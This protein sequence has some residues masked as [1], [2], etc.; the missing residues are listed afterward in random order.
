MRTRLLDKAQEDMWI[1]PEVQATDARGNKMKVPAKEPVKCRVT[2]SVDQGSDAELAGQVSVEV[3]RVLSRDA[4]AGSF[5][6]IVFRE[7]QW[8]LAYPPVFTHGVSRLTRHV[9][10]GIR[11]RNHT[12]G[13]DG[14]LS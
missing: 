3:L 2:V 10:F 5:A 13:T 7:R 6:R 9:E 12:A 11:G 1:Y 4:P 8:D 14:A